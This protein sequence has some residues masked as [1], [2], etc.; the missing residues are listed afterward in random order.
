MKLLLLTH[1][2]DD[3]NPIQTN[4]IPSN[5][6]QVLAFENHT[7]KNSNTWQN[8]EQ[9]CKKKKKKKKKNTIKEIRIELFRVSADRDDRSRMWRRAAFRPVDLAHPL[10]VSAD[11]P[12]IPDL[13][14]KKRN[15]S[16]SAPEAWH[17][18]CF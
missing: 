17:Y 13:G 8:D 9:S 18:T 2:S 11:N 1:S 14:G 3:T 15:E 12:K 10:A 16:T 7:L 4:P 5:P 6:I